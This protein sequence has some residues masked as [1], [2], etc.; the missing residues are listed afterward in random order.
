MKA[1]R[2]H[3][4]AGGTQAVLSWWCRV[5]RCDCMCRAH[6]SVC[7]CL[8]GMPLTVRIIGPRSPAGRGPIPSFAADTRP[9][10]ISIISHNLIVALPPAC[11]AR[12]LNPH[13]PITRQRGLGV[14]LPGTC[15]CVTSHPAALLTSRP[16]LF[17]FCMRTTKPHD[18][19]RALSVAPP[20]A[21]KLWKPEGVVTLL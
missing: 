8:S 4:Q 20:S 15:V 16:C 19:V 18:D 1:T 11:R 10:L 21:S 3:R 7:A 2:S 6:V 9:P 17:P 14:A 5:R 12:Y 13:G